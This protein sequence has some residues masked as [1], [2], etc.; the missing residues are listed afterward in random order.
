MRAIAM[1]AMLVAF[2]PLAATAQTTDSECQ[3]QW[4]AADSNNDGYVTEAESNRFHAAM[5]AQGKS[6]TEGRIAR[7]AFLT[8][9]KAGVFAVK[10]NDPGAPLKG[11][12]SFTEQQA[13]DRALAHGVTNLS[14][15]AKDDDGIW[16]AKAMQS[17]KSVNVSVDF[18]GNVVVN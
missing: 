8:E 6:V 11:A 17:G 3:A 18:K 9:C 7:D 10:A 5:R 2:A 4:M 15:L 12:N 1:A 14:G 13:R 16:R